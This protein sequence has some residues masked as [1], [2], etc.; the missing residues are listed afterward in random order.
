MLDQCQI[1]GF[2]DEINEDFN[3]QLD[4]L[5]ELGQKYIELRSADGIGVAD[6]T[7]EQAGVLGQKME[8]ADVRVSSVGSPIGKIM[9]T[10]DFEPHF[11]TFRHVAEL[12][13]LWSVKYIRMFS[14]Y[15]PEGEEPEQYREEVLT[16]IKRMVTYAGEQGLILLHENEKDIY[17]DTAPRCLELME[18]CYG[19][20]F[21][22]VFDFA[23][24]V[25]CGQDTEEAYEMLKPYI[26]YI[27]IKD[28][29]MEDGEVVLPGDGDGHVKSILSRLDEAGYNGF[30]SLEPHLVS[31]GGLEK[32]EKSAQERRLNDGIDAYRQ[33]YGRLCGLIG[34]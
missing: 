11:E 28:A 13:K 32:L 19:E 33:A 24:F 20:S 21:Q 1:S 17:G 22:C 9:I 26:K 25:Q 3:V 4:V 15:I 34:R 6:L 29:K 16:R 12:A 18:A 23:N 5:K 27:H 14:F 30:L 10:D 8:A 7:P 2:A 31:F